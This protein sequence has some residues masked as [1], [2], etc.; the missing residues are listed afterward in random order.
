MSDLTAFR[1][2]CRREAKRPR[3]VNRS[4]DGEVTSSSGPT[5]PERALWL[6]LADEIDAYL[7]GAVDVD[8]FG[9][10]SEVP[11]TIEESA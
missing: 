2:H 3:I 11:T 7:G 5:E 6:Q 10:L 9:E 1:D 4:A 8:L